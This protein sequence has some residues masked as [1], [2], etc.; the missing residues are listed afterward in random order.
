[1][2]VAPRT[3]RPKRV[4]P[5]LEGEEDALVTGSELVVGIETLVAT[6]VARD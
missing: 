5:V 3:A 6:F 2:T 1:M 4:I